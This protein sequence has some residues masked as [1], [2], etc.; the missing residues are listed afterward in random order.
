MCVPG[1]RQRRVILVTIL[2]RLLWPVVPDAF[3]DPCCPWSQVGNLAQSRVGNSATLLSTGRVLVAGGFGVQGDP[4]KFVEIY[5]PATGRWAPA[6]PMN[7]FRADHTATLLH[8]GKVLVAGGF[9]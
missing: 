6:K 7:V 5:D 8:N 4:K 1:D 3:A 9:N 2:F